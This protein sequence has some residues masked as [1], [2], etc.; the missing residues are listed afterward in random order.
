MKVPASMI[1]AFVVGL[2][3]TG[4]PALYA[5]RRREERKNG[6]RLTIAIVYVLT[7]WAVLASIGLLVVLVVFFG[8]PRQSAWVSEVLYSWGAGISVPS[9]IF[10]RSDLEWRKTWQKP[11]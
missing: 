4:I 3:A 11:R 6:N 2:L 1:M 8:A 7:I 9:V 10:I 5:V